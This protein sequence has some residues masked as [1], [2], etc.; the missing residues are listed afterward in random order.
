MAF[1]FS[2]ARSIRAI[3]S[4]KHFSMSSI[5]ITCPCSTTGKCLNFPVILEHFNWLSSLASCQNVHTHLGPFF[6][7]LQ[8]QEYQK[9]QKGGFVSLLL[10]QVCFQ[11]QFHEHIIHSNKECIKFS[12]GMWAL[13][14]TLVNQLSIGRQWQFHQ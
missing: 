5:A 10:I 13:N 7:R 3:A 2:A 14:Q 11:S 1:P 9:V 6:V 8:Q 4:Y 12:I